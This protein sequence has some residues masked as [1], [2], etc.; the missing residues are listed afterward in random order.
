ML[1]EVWI[2]HT[3]DYNQELFFGVESTFIGVF[4]FSETGTDLGRN[5]ITKA[6]ISAFAPTF[7]AVLGA[8]F[9]SEEVDVRNVLKETFLRWNVPYGNFFR[10][11]HF[12][13]TATQAH[14]ASSQI[15]KKHLIT[16]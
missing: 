16:V 14:S 2:D 3:H 7:N 9:C 8:L 5:Q 12:M 6:L 10:T 4:S 11:K 15:K 13:F 1:R